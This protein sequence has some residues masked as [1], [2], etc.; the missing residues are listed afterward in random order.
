M[1]IDK[2][3]KDKM[4]FFFEQGKRYLDAVSVPEERKCELR[5]YAERMMKRNY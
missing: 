2:M 5:A 4:D 3:A 1:G